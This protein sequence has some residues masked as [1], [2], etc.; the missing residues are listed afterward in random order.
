VRQ[1]ENVPTQ[2]EVTAKKGD[3]FDPQGLAALWKR[4]DA[5][6]SSVHFTASD[7]RKLLE[8]VRASGF[9]PRIDSPRALE[10]EAIATIRTIEPQL[11]NGIRQ[12]R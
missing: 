6:S 2:P 5:V 10:F 9:R 1:P 12:P 8:A 4:H 7:A 11:N 3:V